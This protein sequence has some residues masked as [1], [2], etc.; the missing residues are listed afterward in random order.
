M[1]NKKSTEFLAGDQVCRLRSF[2]IIASGTS[3]SF[4]NMPRLE[5]MA[6]RLL[7]SV[8]FI[9]PKSGAAVKYNARNVPVPVA[10]RTH[11]ATFRRLKSRYVL[12]DAI[13]EA[14]NILAED[15][16]STLVP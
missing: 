16:R 7:M 9:A 3:S 13:A 5:N 15:V 1:S 8:R 10:S 12:A 6:L 4:E 14:D 11:S 2:S